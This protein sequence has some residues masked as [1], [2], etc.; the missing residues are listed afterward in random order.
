MQNRRKFVLSTVTWLK[1][2]ARLA[3]ILSLRFVMKPA[4]VTTTSFVTLKTT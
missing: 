2:F 3:S 4:G 1:K